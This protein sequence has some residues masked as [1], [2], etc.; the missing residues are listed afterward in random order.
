MILRALTFLFAVASLAAAPL[1]RI[2]VSPDGKHFVEKG[3]DRVFVPWGFNYD[4]DSKGRL[5]E[6]YWHDEWP[7]VVG[8]FE[9]MKALGANVVRIHL[10]LGKVMITPDQPDPKTLAR[11]ARLIDLAGE[12][13]LY[14]DLTGLGC[15]HAKDI[16]PWYDA[17]P[18]AKRWAVQAR[19][20]KAVAETAKGR[21][22]IFCYD[23]MNEPIV[24]GGDKIET[25]WLAGELGG[26]HF[27][28]RIALDPAGRKP[29]EIAR[30]WVRQMSDSIREVDRDTLLTVGV[31]PWATV[32][33]NAK[34]L[35][36]SPEAGKPLDFVSVHFYP[37]RGK[38]DEALKAL[39]VYEV[40]KPLVIEEIFPL[41]C[42][43][44]ELENFIDRS[45][46]TVD[47]WIGFYWG[48]PPDQLDT[49]EMS[50][51]ITRGWLEYFQRNAARMK[52]G[53]K[54]IESPG[55]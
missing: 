24:P 44:A 40:G 36:H 3:S 35:F 42:D 16:P 34:P 25:E 28:Q 49:K 5:I 8:D 51:A 1:P 18:E 30:D 38:I 45:S 32:F 43:L 22:E 31:I 47:G 6:D 50:G 46:A 2:A 17:L 9:E 23:L 11:L 39:A 7:A 37:E 26:K 53:G 15:Y 21:P 29:V 13:G 12:K 20:W 48:T 10:Q 27:V 52:A 55:K 14:L 19:F 4:H 33:P 54:P 41:K